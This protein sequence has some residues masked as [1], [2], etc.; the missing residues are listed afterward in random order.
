MQA[1]KAEESKVSKGWAWTQV[2]PSSVR[3]SRFFSLVTVLGQTR[4]QVTDVCS[5]SRP[6]NQ[7]KMAAVKQWGSLLWG[8]TARRRLRTRPL[9]TLVITSIRPLL[10][11][12]PNNNYCITRWPKR[13]GIS[14][15]YFR[16]AIQNQKIVTTRRSNADMSGANLHFF[17]LWIA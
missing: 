13:T 7:S 12:S 9:I 4:L 5:C 1:A 16:F 8:Q 2:P 10:C 3:Q 15:T 6:I 11:P 17:V 14:Q